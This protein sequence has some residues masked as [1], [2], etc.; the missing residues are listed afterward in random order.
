MSQQTFAV[1]YCGHNN[2]DG[3]HVPM[4]LIRDKDRCCSII[5]ILSIV[6]SLSFCYHRSVLGVVHLQLL[7][8]VYCEF[9]CSASPLCGCW[10]CAPLESE[11][12]CHFAIVC[13]R[14]TSHFEQSYKATDFCKAKTTCSQ[15][16]MELTRRRLN[17]KSRGYN[18]GSGTYNATER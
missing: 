14:Q 3:Q 1:Y 16:T 11:C 15:Q 7:C 4:S 17:T 12:V 2:Y 10:V 8:C 13:S 5:G 18:I 9:R 6:F